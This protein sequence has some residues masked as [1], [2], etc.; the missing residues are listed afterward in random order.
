MIAQ[1]TMAQVCGGSDVHVVVV[2]VGS[3]RIAALSANMPG[4]KCIYL[5][6]AFRSMLLIL[7]A[8][9]CA[10]ILIVRIRE[11]SDSA[12]ARKEGDGMRK[13][14]CLKERG[15]EGGKSINAGNNEVFRVACK[16]GYV[17]VTM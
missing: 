6:V 13:V 14:L 12:S 10:R 16:R 8:S 1:E 2:V 15:R 3:G 4:S 17:Y 7:D 9:I 5:L 11:K